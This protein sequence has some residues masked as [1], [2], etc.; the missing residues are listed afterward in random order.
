MKI[1]GQ[2]IKKTYK[3]KLIYENFPINLRCIIIS[4]KNRKVHLYS[5][6]HHI[7]HNIIRKENIPCK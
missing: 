5:Y 3:K 2:S 6:F 7:S 4:V 1:M